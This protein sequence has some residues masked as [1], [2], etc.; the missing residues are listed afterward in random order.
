M[1][2]R[3]LVIFVVGIFSL[4]PAADAMAQPHWGHERMPH[5]GA[6]FYEDKDFRGRYFCVPTG[7]DLRNL[8]GG[9]NDRISSMR[10]LGTQEVTVFKDS[11]MRGRSA[12]F[13][14]DVRDLKRDGWNDQI[15]SIVVTGRV[16]GH[17]GVYGDRDRTGVH[18][19][20]HWDV[21]GAPVWG[22]ATLPR[23]G[24]CF[25]EDANFHGQYFCVPRGAAYA[26]L[27]R[28]FNDRIVSIRVFGSGVRIYRDHDF[29]GTSR[30]IRHDAAN[31]RG[32][33][34]DVISSV[35]VE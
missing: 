29:H 32:D 26:S 18:G 4:L 22:R 34:R 8:P 10:V 15:S 12:H 25:Y 20:G 27:P 24:A 23:E 33:W 3:K 5:A 35:R 16:Y 21:Y 11:D 6:C 1:T 14:G 19:D 9:M 2:T 30:E 7:E 17:E 13:S 31:L 28:G